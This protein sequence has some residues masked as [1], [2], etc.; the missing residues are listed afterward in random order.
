MKNTQLCHSS[1]AGEVQELFPDYANKVFWT[2]IYCI[3]CNINLCIDKG[4]LLSK[5]SDGKI[6]Y[7]VNCPKFNVSSCIVFILQYYYKINV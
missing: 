5:R 1:Q 3:V 4:L 6:S 2:Q 7:S